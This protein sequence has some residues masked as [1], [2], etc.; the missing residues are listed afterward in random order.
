MRVGLIV[1]GFSFP[2]LDFARGASLCEFAVGDE[3]SRKRVAVGRRASVGRAGSMA[4]PGGR[5]SKP[6]RSFSVAAS[7]SASAPTG[8]RI[9]AN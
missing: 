9:R 7:N 4:P 6:C 8:I 2:D 3:A 1:P 5:R